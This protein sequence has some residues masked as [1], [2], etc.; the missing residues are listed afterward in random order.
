MRNIELKGE[1]IASFGQAK[2]VRR[3]DGWYELLGGRVEDRFEARE[4]ASFFLHE[5][6]LGDRPVLSS[7]V[8]DK[9]L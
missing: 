9:M 3:K 6:V 7:G 5:A 8:G 1:L 2:I 4:W